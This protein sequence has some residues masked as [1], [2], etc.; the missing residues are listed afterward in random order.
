MQSANSQIALINRHLYSGLKFRSKDD[1]Y[2]FISY[3]YNDVTIKF[4]DR[5]EDIPF[6]LFYEVMLH[7]NKELL[8]IWSALENE[9]IYKMNE[10]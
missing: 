4:F 5:Y 9:S 1:E 8:E 3:D 2:T 7:D 10:I 6:D